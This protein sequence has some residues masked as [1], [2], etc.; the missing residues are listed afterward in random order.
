MN[1]ENKIQME[2]MPDA[3]IET[4]REYLFSV[5][6]DQGGLKVGFQTPENQDDT[7]SAVDI[8]MVVVALFKMLKEA[9]LTREQINDFMS[10]IS[11]EIESADIV[12]VSSPGD[13]HVEKKE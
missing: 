6:E 1:Q 9:G 3:A 2:K 5:E 8:S 10:N 7:M 12:E 11:N 13:I 4:K